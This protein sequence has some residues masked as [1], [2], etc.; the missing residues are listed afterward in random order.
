MKRARHRRNARLGSRALFWVTGL[1]YRHEGSVQE[2]HT[3]LGKMHV[4]V[5]RYVLS[6]KA[7]E[8]YRLRAGLDIPRD[9]WLQK[10]LHTTKARNEA[11]C[12]HWMGVG[13]PGEQPGDR[14]TRE[15][16]TQNEN[17]ALQSAHLLT[18]SLCR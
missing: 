3:F 4:G 7:H 1:T 18:S 11:G 5:H 6:R 16:D 10:V 13:P 8:E 9:D 2:L 15:E 17:P 14:A 12:V